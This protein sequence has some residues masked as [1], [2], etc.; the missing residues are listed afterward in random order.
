M[1]TRLTDIRKLLRDLL[2]LAHGSTVMEY[3][4]I[5]AIAIAVL[6]LVFLAL[7]KILIPSL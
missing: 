4:M 6:A 2:D 7:L 5:F 3:V 1:A